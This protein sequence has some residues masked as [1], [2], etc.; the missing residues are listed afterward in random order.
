MMANRV[1][2]DPIDWSRGVL[3]STESLNEQWADNLTW[4]HEP[5]AARVTNSIDQDISTGVFSTISYDT[6]Y[7][8]NDDVFGT[9]NPTRMTAVR[10]G[11]HLVFGH[12]RISWIAAGGIVDSKISHTAGTITND[13]AFHDIETASGVTTRILLY[14][15]LDMAVGDYIETS[16]FHNQAGDATVEYDSERNS[17]VMGMNWMGSG[18][19]NNSEWTIPRDWVDGEL[20]TAANHNKHIRSNFKYLDL[21][22]GAKVSRSSA[23]SVS[24]STATGIQFSTEEWDDNNYFSSGANTRITIPAAGKYMITGKVKF[25]ANTTGYR[26]VFFFLNGTTNIH[27]EID[28]PVT[29][30]KTK[31]IL[32]PTVFEFAANDYIELYVFQTSGGALDLTDCTFC[33]NLL[34]D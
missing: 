12:S 23:Q 26:S 16:I 30:R 6:E 24:D 28:I 29:G 21:K 15:V 22:H 18:D 1:W 11:R 14:D 20:V 8:D 7:Y 31:I 10:A 3:V 17:P 32:A 33:I 13:V 2:N 4:L 9:A 34:S 19:V 5:Q 27:N 25:E